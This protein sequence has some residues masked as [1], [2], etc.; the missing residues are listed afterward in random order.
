MSK[1]SFINIA[2]CLFITAVFL[3]PAFIVSAEPEN[4]EE[5]VCG[6]A[7]GVSDGYISED[8]L[9]EMGDDIISFQQPDAEVNVL[10]PT[11]P[12]N[13]KVYKQQT[14]TYCS[15]ATVY[16]TQ[17]FLKYS[18][19]SSQATIMKYWKTH[20]DS[21]VPDLPAVRNYL[22]D[23]AYKP[24]IYHKYKVWSGSLT[25][26]SFNTNLKKD[27]ENKQPTILVI[28]NKSG[29]SKWPFQT[30]GHF[31]MCIGYQ[32]SNSAGPYLIGDPYYFSGYVS[33]AGTTGKH[34]RTW[35]QLSKAIKDRFSDTQRYLTT[36]TSSQ[37]PTE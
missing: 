21:S 35:S 1:K 16:S 22:N 26:L 28:S 30:N 34:Y 32:A 29:D 2:I 18:S 5:P 4:N 6:Y 13:L 9:F 12:L 19:V 23:S 3:S 15:A 31:C 24:S 20:Y 36:T 11:T 37:N 10:M 8:D 7:D 27:I 25:Q 17:K 33:G 14:K